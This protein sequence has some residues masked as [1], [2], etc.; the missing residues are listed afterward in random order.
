MFLSVIALLVSVSVLMHNVSVN[1]IRGEYEQEIQRLQDSISNIKTDT[2]Y[3]KDDWSKLIESVIITESGGN[4]KAVG[5]ANDVG[6]MQIR[7]I[8]VREVNRI[9]KEERYVLDDRYDPMKS[10]EMFHII[11]DHYNP[12]RD[13]HK[14]IKLHNKADWYE[15]K[16]LAKMEEV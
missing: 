7:P 13:I 6:C 10:L 3:L 16:I 9:L 2:V 8:Y 1:R 4:P 11:Q 12:G 5:K 14:A 15:R